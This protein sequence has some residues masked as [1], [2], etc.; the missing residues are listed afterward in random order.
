M[1]EPMKKVVLLKDGTQL[2]ATIPQ[3]EKI[4]AA[5]MSTH[6]FEKIQVK[7]NGV[8]FKLGDIETDPEKRAAVNQQ[9][10]PLN[11]EEKKLPRNM[12]MG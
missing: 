10:M 12:D 3:L 9:S 5:I 11:V 7:L 4:N 8:Y 1:K 6:E 2:E